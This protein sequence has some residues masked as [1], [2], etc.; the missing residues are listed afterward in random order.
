MCGPVGSPG[1]QRASFAHVTLAK[2]RDPAQLGVVTRGEDDALGISTDAGRAAEDEVVLAEHRCALLRGAS[3]PADRYRLAGEHGH[4]DLERAIGQAGV[5]RHLAALAEQ[6]Y[7]TGYDVTNLDRALPCIAYDPGVLGQV[8]GERLDRPLRLPLL[9][10]P[11]DQLHRPA[12]AEGMSP[13][14]CIT[15]AWAR[16]CLN[17]WCRWPAR[18]MSARSAPRR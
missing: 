3:D 15:G 16:C 4:V 2:R 9:Q 14:R 17:T 1:C 6:H 13:R 12:K 8:T 7:V 5:C 10:R 18:A 11:A